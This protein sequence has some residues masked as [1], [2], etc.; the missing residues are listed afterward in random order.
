MDTMIQNPDPEAI[1]S[2]TRIG[3]RS[4]IWIGKS[5]KHFLLS[6]IRESFWNLKQNR[7]DVGGCGIKLTLTLP[8]SSLY[9]PGMVKIAIQLDPDYWLKHEFVRSLDPVEY[10]AYTRLALTACSQ[11]LPND[12]AKIA[13]IAELNLEAATKLWEKLSGR[14]MP[15]A[16]NPDRLVHF[17]SIYVEPSHKPKVAKNATTLY[18]TSLYGGTISPTTMTKKVVENYDFDINLLWDKFPKRV[19][20]KA[21]EK[22]SLLKLSQIVTSK[23]IYIKLE[24]AID[25]YIKTLTKGQK[26]EDV[27]KFTKKMP[28]WLLEWEAWVPEEA[29]RSEAKIQ[30]SNEGVT[31]CRTLNDLVRT[32]QQLGWLPNYV[33]ADDLPWTSIYGTKTEMELIGQWTEDRKKEFLLKEVNPTNKETVCQQLKVMKMM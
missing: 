9:W 17:N 30:A 23:D 22:D 4:E 3:E 32:C 20:Y 15:S 19:A 24:Q 27:Q 8:N 11:T 7:L 25:N 1:R 12:L 33:P 16:H 28:Q 6:R 5:L 2:I 18:G 29:P 14:F 31:K 21:Y 13:E 26:K 10:K